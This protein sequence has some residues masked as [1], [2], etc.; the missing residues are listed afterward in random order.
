MVLSRRALTVAVLVLQAASLSYG[1]N[2]AARQDSN[3]YAANSI[4][5]NV[6]NSM[7]YAESANILQSLSK[8]D[9]L[10]VSF[11]NCV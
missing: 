11:E 9:K 3:Y 6:R 10:Y 1:A 2:E 7:Y 4:N 5:P 8:F